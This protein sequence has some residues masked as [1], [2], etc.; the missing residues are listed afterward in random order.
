[1][2]VNTVSTFRVFIFLIGLFYFDNGYFSLYN[3]F[4]I[5]GEFCAA[6]IKRHVLTD[7][8]EK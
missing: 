1:M 6:L 7:K 4:M 2:L 5:R 8:K 3:R